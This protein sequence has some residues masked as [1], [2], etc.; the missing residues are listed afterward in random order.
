MWGAIKKA[1]NSNLN[2][3][4]D[5]LIQEKSN[6]IISGVNKGCVKSV[7]RGVAKHGGNTTTGY[8][9]INLKNLVNPSKCLVVINGVF[10]SS[11][12]QHYY[13]H[14]AICT[15]LTPTT[16]RVQSTAVGKPYNNF[17]S[18]SWQVVEFY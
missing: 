6:E 17:Y 12:E 13:T 18:V 11:G 4:L 10:D 1:I 9:I 16:I 7:Q 14:D 2:K 15:E 3:S 8:T 5:V